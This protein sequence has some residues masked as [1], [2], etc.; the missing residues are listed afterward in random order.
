[1]PPET[2]N[3]LLLPTDETQLLPY[4]LPAKQEEALSMIKEQS[5]PLSSQEAELTSLAVQRMQQVLT[6]KL[7]WAC[8]A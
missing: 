3:A 6:H 7:S 4:G 2:I 5:S 8:F 1:M